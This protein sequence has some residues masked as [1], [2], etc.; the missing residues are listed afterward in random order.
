MAVSLYKDVKCKGYSSYY[1]Y[2]AD[3][4]ENSYSIVNNTSNVTIDFYMNAYGSS[5]GFS[6]YQ[7]C[8]FGI[9]VDGARKSGG[10]SAAK[11]VN[12]GA[13]YIYI[14]TWTGDVAHDTD[15]KKEITVGLT[16]RCNASTYYSDAYLPLQ[17][18]GT[19]SYPSGT[20]LI[21]D[22]GKVSLTTI[23]RAS[24][25]TA[26]DGTLGT[27]QTLT[28]TRYATSFTHTIT[29]TC[30]SASG[31][32]CTKSSNTSVSFTPPL[33]LASQNTT[34][35]Q[36][37]VVLTI[38]T[39]SGNT[40]IGSARKTIT[41]AI[42]A[43]VKPSCSLSVADAMGY[44]NTYG[45][46]VKG[47]SMFEVDITA[48]GAYGSEIT[49]YKTTVDGASYPWDSF[50]TDVIKTAG[51]LTITT[52]VTD[53]RERTETA[54]VNVTVL[55]YAA[56]SISNL[57]AVRSNSDGTVNEQ[58]E[59]VKVVF[60]SAVTSLNSKNTA[61]YTL[62]YKKSTSTS[63]TYVTLSQYNNNYAV[64]AG[65][66]VFAADTGSSYD[67][68][69][70]LTD[71]F[72]G[73]TKAT[74]APTGFA[75][76]HW[77][78]DGTAVGIGKIA[79]RS[80]SLD[81]GVDI[82]LNDNKVLRDGVE[83]FAPAF[84]GI[85]KLANFPVANDTEIDDVLISVI[86]GI[87]DQM[88]KRVVLS[89]TTTD[90]FTNGG[91]HYYADVYKL[92]TNYALITVKSYINGGRELRRV[93]F[94]GELE[95]WEWVNPPMAVGIE[96]RTTERYNGNVIYTKAASFGALPNNSEKGV[97]LLDANL[98][99]IDFQGFAE[100]NYRVPVPGYSGVSSAGYTPST[101]NVWVATN[102]NMSSYNAYFIF[103]YYK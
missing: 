38:T 100:G 68:A 91:G 47:R 87:D 6:S 62:R 76:I 70:E 45:G 61:A 51:A 25:L 97:V 94:E 69:L 20:P 18:D 98:H 85:G 58:G 73:I 66:Y 22:M 99:V 16:F 21:W 64:S 36:V 80:Y 83:A 8:Q 12:S 33:S 13:T 19:S 86:N 63:Y 23:P 4:T 41:C 32:I 37:S 90:N 49:S 39:Y 82:E 53:S 67:I 55:N 11:T 88:F 40:E 92:S 10:Q 15:G 59:Y 52:T 34:G 30:G 60:G 77:K 96:Y 9:Y 54:S 50:T 48:A 14:G 78:A 71:A 101:G 5:A 29:Y 65:T 103:K 3:V 28:V 35:V 89:F 57:T 81:M 84:F 56:P 79:E 44:A 74:T 72:S 102:T 75:I 17:N 27:Q 46:Y 93:W 1:S 2:R 42:P 31:T 43:S 24:G 26:S 95:P 7:T